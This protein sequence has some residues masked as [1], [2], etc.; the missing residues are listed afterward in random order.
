[1]QLHGKNKITAFK[2]RHPDARSK[3]ESWE[4]EIEAATW[5]NPIEMKQRYPTADP[6]GNTNTIFNIMGNKYRLWVQINYQYQIALVK[7]AGT[8][9]EYMKWKI[10]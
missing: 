7:E 10:K 2:D 6:I 8:H 4:A 5:S 1:M 9:E 3:I